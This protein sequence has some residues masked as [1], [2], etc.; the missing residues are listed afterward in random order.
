MNAVKRAAF[1]TSKGKC[2]FI[3]RQLSQVTQDKP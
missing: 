3:K 2:V 1:M